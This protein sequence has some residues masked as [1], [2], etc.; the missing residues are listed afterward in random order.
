[1]EAAVRK[2]TFDIAA[3]W[4]LKKR[5]LIREGWHADVVVFDPTSIAP[6]LPEFVHDL[7]AGASRI[8]QK[9]V[10]IKAT[11]VNG[12]IFMRDNMHTGALSGRLLR[13]RLARR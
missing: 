4:G 6:D 5:G 2:I 1:M 9:A 7:P 8:L 12:A 13:G 3:F 10:G 11:V